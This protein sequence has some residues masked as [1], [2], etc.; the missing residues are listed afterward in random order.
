MNPTAAT[1]DCFELLSLPRRAALSDEAISAAY[2]EKS[3]AVHPDHGGQ[4][5][6]AAQMNAAHETLRTPERRLK[7]LIELQAPEDAKAWRT[8]PLDDSMMATFLSLGKA[9]EASAQFL[10]RKS[11]AQSAVAKALLTGEELRLREELEALG[12]EI[13]KCR[14]ALVEQLPELDA[15]I[16][17]SDRDVW[18]RI[19]MTQARFAY[20]AKWQTQIRERLLRLM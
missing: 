5:G 6:M 19:G 14:Q 9:M 15:A 18:R 17:V 1:V 8:V 3:R 13:E 11:R 7:H 20:L 16:D 10:E 2:L 4:E 12:F